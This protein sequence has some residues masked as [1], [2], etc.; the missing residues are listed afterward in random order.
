MRP[1]MGVVVYRKVHRSTVVYRKVHRSTVVYRGVH[2]RTA[3]YWGVHRRTAVY[4]GVQED[5]ERRAGSSRPTG[6]LRRIAGRD[7]SSRAGSCI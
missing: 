6:F 3:V 7:G 1:Y 5:G 4:W 2:R